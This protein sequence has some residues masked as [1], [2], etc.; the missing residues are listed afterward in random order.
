MGQQAQAVRKAPGFNRE[1][2]QIA[3]KRKSLFDRIEK[4]G[5]VRGF[6]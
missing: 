4:I 3:S 2:A 5:K 6:S 1:W